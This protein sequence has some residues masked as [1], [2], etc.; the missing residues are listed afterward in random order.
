MNN[1]YKNAVVYGNAVI[2]KD[3]NVYDISD[4]QNIPKPQPSNY[5]SQGK[6]KCAP[7][8]PIRSLEDI[9]AIK[10]FF[11][12]TGR[13]SLRMRNYMMFVLGISVGLRGC[14]LLNLRIR[15]VLHVNG[16]IVDEIHAYE[17]KTHKM[18]HPILNNEA[19]KAIAA[20][21]NSLKSYDPDDY[22]IT[23][24]GNSKMDGNTL[25]NIIKSAQIKLNLPYNL[26][27]HSLRKTFAYWTVAM[28]P[29]D[30]NILAS[31]QE[32]LNHDNMKTTLHYSGQT[33]DHLRTLYSDI[34]KVFTGEAKNVVSSN[35]KGD[36]ESKLDTIIG[37]L[38]SE[39]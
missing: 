33:K 5:T 38:C 24:R 26:G 9:E 12:T 25:Y 15:D 35:A 8:D 16:Y 20:Y 27:A 19:K 30:M 22:L 10:D 36:V 34:E 17:S 18:N 29:N 7:C 31:L 4:R 11:L 1:Y 6:R 2:K 13:E 39:D 23:A 32:M 14:D 37:L 3:C 28:H 21:L